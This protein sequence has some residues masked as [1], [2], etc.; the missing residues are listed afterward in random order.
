[1]SPDHSSFDP[2]I[3]PKSFGP[4][5]DYDVQK[6]ERHPDAEGVPLTVLRPPDRFAAEPGLK[7][8][9]RE[10]ISRYARAWTAAEE[11]ERTVDKFRK[12]NRSTGDGLRH[13]VHQ[14]PPSLRTGS[15][16]LWAAV[17]VR[18]LVGERAVSVWPSD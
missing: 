6:M 10:A 11:L 5:I 9:T 17:G 13:D 7:A 3:A 1:M 16:A 18:A 15:S 12:F 4:A 2:A 8:A 14:K